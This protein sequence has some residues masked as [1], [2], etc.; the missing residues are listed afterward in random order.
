M[1]IGAM[2]APG[3]VVTVSDPEAPPVSPPLFAAVTEQVYA[4][5]PVKPLTVIGEPLPVAVRVACPVATQ[6]AV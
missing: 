6:V 4:I 3:P 2:L 5:P 1:K